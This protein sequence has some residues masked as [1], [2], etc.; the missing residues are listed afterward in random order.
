MEL[1]HLTKYPNFKNIVEIV[2]NKSHLQKSKILNFHKKVDQLYFE[3]AE[4]FSINF[5]NF[6]KSQKTDLEVATNA[7]L[8]MCADMMI[9][10]LYFY[11]HN[12]YPLNEQKEA[13]EKV[14]DNVQEMKSLCLWNSNFPISVVNTLCYVLFFI[15]EIQKKKNKC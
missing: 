4:N 3:R 14:Y 8:K 10:H 11:K 12:K 9:S 7:Y 15:N 1:S 2:I 13:F 5:I 6:L